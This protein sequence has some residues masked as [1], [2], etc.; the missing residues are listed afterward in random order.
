MEYYPNHWFDLTGEAT[1]GFTHQNDD[2]STFELTPRI[3]ARLHILSDLRE[4]L[5]PA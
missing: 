2:V 3:G 5:R 4:K 1:V